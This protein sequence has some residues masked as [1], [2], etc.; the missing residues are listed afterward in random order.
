[1]FAPVSLHPSRLSLMGFDVA[2]DKLTSAESQIRRAMAAVISQTKP[3]A[4]PKPHGKASREEVR[5]ILFRAASV[6]YGDCLDSKNSW[7]SVP[8]AS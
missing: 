8:V 1:M 6:D 2:I 4:S 7:N 5:N 3:P